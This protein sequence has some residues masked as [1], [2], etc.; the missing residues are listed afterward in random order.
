MKPERIVARDQQSYFGIPLD[1]NNRN[2]T[3]RL[4]FDQKKQKHMGLLDFDKAE[5]RYPI[6]SLEDIYEYAD[7]IRDVVRRVRDS[8]NS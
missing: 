8:G 4:H 2:T 3:A 7:A 1:D 5:M 6:A